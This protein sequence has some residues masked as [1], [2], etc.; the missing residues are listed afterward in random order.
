MS[1]RFLVV[2]IA[3]SALLWCSSASAESAQSAF[4][5]VMSTHA[6]LD[7]QVRTFERATTLATRT[8][9][10]GDPMA[11]SEKLDDLEDT[12]AEAK[13]ARREFHAALIAF[14]DYLDDEGIERESTRAFRRSTELADQMAIRW[15]RAVETG[16]IVLEARRR[17]VCGNPESDACQEATWMVKERALDSV[18]AAPQS[19][20]RS[21]PLDA[22]NPRL[23]STN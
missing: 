16:W 21:C 9:G 11:I 18:G 19:A 14:A 6:T 22:A 3:A 4:G 1:V 20:A 12:R 23:P 17:Q 13:A 15:S 5:R 10:T 2:F 8:M 7:K